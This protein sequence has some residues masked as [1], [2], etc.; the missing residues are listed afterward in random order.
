MQKNFYVKTYLPFA[1]YPPFP[2]MI[3]ECRVTP[4][5]FDALAAFY[6]T[7][8][9][10]EAAGLLNLTS[11][12]INAHL[13]NFRIDK[14]TNTNK[15]SEGI[16]RYLDSCHKN[17]KE[18]LKQHYSYL[19]VEKYF[20][21]FLLGIFNMGVKNKKITCSLSYETKTE[22][23]PLKQIE[24]HLTLVGIKIEKKLDA[25]ESVDYVLEVLSAELAPSSIDII[26][27]QE[28]I[29]S[30]QLIIKKRQ[31]EKDTKIGRAHV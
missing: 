2:T 20:K 22:I 13:R 26:R 11:K 12:G 27:K 1:F 24:N 23:L 31:K 17:T 5:Q 8:D 18:M 19:L 28:T 10:K 29:S 14:E 16:V 4:H 9:V 15:I 25:K 30:F 7:R 3:G 21:E 6:S